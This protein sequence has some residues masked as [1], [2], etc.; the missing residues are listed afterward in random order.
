MRRYTWII[1]AIVSLANLAP[2]KAMTAENIATVEN[3]YAFDSSCTDQYS[4][5]NTQQ[6][7]NQVQ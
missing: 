3:Y 1:F 6:L 5:I 2:L 4:Q 7:M